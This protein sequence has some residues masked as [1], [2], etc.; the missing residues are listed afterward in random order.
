MPRETGKCSFCVDSLEP[1]RLLA[2]GALDPS[3]SGDGKLLVDLRTPFN[4]QTDTFF[5]DVAG[6]PTGRAAAI[7]WGAGGTAHGESLV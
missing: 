3:F 6:L 4:G 5:T 1:R 2:A 7:D